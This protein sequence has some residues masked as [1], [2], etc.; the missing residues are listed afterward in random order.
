MFLNI[1]EIRLVNAVDATTE[2]LA[3]S[4]LDTKNTLIY[5]LIFGKLPS[6]FR[7]HIK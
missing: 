6:L 3:H 7:R 2:K 1:A 5:D 4:T